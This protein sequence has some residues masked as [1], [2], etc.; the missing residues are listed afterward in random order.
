V[1][2]EGLKL[3]FQDLET[4]ELQRF[5]NEEKSFL[6]ATSALFITYNQLEKFPETITKTE[7]RP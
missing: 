4:A 1:K 3:V 6:L 2:F 5:C 7:N